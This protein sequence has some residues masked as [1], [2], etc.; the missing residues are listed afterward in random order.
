MTSCGAEPEL[1]LLDISLYLLSLVSKVTFHDGTFRKAQGV[2]PCHLVLVIS[3]VISGSSVMRYVGG[4][5]LWIGFMTWLD[6]EQTYC[7]DSLVQ[8]SHA[9]VQFQLQLVSK[10]LSPYLT[11]KVMSIEVMFNWQLRCTNHVWPL[12]WFVELSFLHSILVL[13]ESNR[14]LSVIARS[15]CDR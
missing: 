14:S 6:T 1:L 3:Q 4:A 13:A 9:L 2:C 15:N 8:M 12:S 7:E 11:E 5:P 10:H